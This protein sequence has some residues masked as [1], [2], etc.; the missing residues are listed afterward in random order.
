MSPALADWR[1]D[2]AVMGAMV[3][4]GFNELVRVPG[5]AIPGIV[6]PSIFMLGLTAVFGDLSRLP[7][8]TAD[9]FLSFLVPISL[10][11]AAGFSG[12]AMGVNLARDIE[13]GWFDRMLVSRVPRTVLLGGLLVSA[14]LRALLPITVALAIAF[15]LG[16]AFPG[17]DGLLIAVGVVLGFA[18]AVA[19]WSVILALRFQTQAA[20]PLMQA[21]V[22]VAVLFTTSY[23]PEELLTGWL[24][25][26][27]RY[28]PVTQVVETVRQGFV[29]GVSWSDTWPGLLVVAALGAA[30]AAF[31]LRA[32]T[33]LGR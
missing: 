10:L 4:R 7:G 22:F 25:E 12:A 28:N 31:A 1:A 33:R 20:A 27:A 26:V 23:A 18:A 8:F 24:R 9:G 21:S 2:L 15:P 6:A 19:A 17:V 11:Q 13:L 30:L 3:R 5:G 14:S 16:A 32:L 29:G